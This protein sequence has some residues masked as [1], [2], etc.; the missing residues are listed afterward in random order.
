MQPF[1]FKSVY[2]CITSNKPKRHESFSIAFLVLF[3][4][5]NN[6]SIAQSDSDIYTNASFS[7][8]SPELEIS[9]RGGSVRVM[10]DDVTSTEVRVFVRQGRSYLSKSDIS[11]EDLGLEMYIEGDKI[12]ITSSYAGRSRGWFSSTPSV[13]YHI[14]TPKSAKV[15]GTTSGGSMRAENIH[16]DLNY[17]TC[18][19]SI[20]VN[21]ASGEVSLSTSGGSIRIETV[22]GNLSANTSGGSIRVTDATGNINVRTSG[23]SLRMDNIDGTLR[24]KTSGGSIRANVTRITGALDLET[25]GGSISLT[26]PY[27]NEGYNFDLR[28]NRVNVDLKQF[29]GTAERNSVSGKMYD[30]KNSVRARTSGGTVTVNFS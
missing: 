25:S 5:F 26:L 30:G 23:G 27:D 22:K 28:G 15:N 6:F 2:H 18:G 13:S 16:G 14:V 19:G 1:G 3:L 4:S 12:I 17:K 10:G 29:T 7:H 11:K 20:R 9:T 21:N 8:P 24:G